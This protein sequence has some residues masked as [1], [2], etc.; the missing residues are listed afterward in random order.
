M[1]VTELEK[2]FPTEDQIP[3]EYNL[4][5]PIEQREYLVNGEMRLWAGKTQDVWSP[6]YVKTE[7]GLEQKRIGS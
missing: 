6:V 1:N 4:T 3:V 5:E 2:L 7:N